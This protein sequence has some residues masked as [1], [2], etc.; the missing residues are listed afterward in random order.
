[1]LGFSTQERPTGA[2]LV[3][4]YKNCSQIG[5]PAIQ[6]E[7]KRDE[8]VKQKALG[9]LF[10]VY[11]YLMEWNNEDAVK[12]FSVMTSY[13]TRGNGYKLKMKKIQSKP[14]KNPFLFLFYFEESQTLVHV[15]Q[16]V[17]V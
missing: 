4:V 15:S 13:R 10:S 17:C 3:K 9:H 2:S 11:K 6:G 7:V 8:P 1:M 5:A 16:T 12:L 14:K